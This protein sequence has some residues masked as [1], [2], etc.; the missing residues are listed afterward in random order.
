MSEPSAESDCKKQTGSQKV[1]TNRRQTLVSVLVA[2]SPNL[3]RR[4][5]TVPCSVSAENW[6]DCEEKHG[7]GS[8]LKSGGSDSKR[9]GLAL[10]GERKGTVRVKPAGRG[11]MPE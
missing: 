1:P 2:C 7:T 10:P 9:T 11:I 5:F 6:C 3:A 4:S 8:G